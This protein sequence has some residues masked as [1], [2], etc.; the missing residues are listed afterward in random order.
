VLGEYEAV[1]QLDVLGLSEA[2]LRESVEW[3]YRNHVAEVTDHEPPNAR[4]TTMYLKLTRALRDRLVPL[5]WAADN[6]LNFCK[7]VDPTNAHFIVVAGGDEFTGQREG[8][9]PGTRSAKGRAS[10]DAIGQMVLDLGEIPRLPRKSDGRDMWVLLVYV[11]EASDQ[12]WYELSLPNRVSA[13]GR[14]DHWEKRIVLSPISISTTFAIESE[15]PAE[16]PEIEVVR[17]TTEA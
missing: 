12:I 4:G 10:R 15:P 1:G 9:E 6:M 11:N 13:N 2:V 3:A 7:V 17:R 14:I 8:R 16:A 5:G